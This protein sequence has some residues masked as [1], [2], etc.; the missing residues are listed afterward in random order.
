M[1]RA[2]CS[3]PCGHH[4]GGCWPAAA[5]HRPS[6]PESAPSAV[7]QGHKHDLHVFRMCVQ[8]HLFMFQFVVSYALLGMPCDGSHGKGPQNPAVRQDCMPRHAQSQHSLRAAMP[9][10]LG[11]VLFFAL[12]HSSC[13]VLHRP[14]MGSIPSTG[15]NAFACHGM[16]AR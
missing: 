2:E 4:D 15:L 3:P 6:R 16:H 14:R 12:V 10:M 7:R 13:V 11:N 8:S 9:R 5:H 1:I